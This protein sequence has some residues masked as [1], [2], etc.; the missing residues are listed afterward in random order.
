MGSGAD[1]VEIRRGP[2]AVR[3]LRLQ[4][5]GSLTG[6]AFTGSLDAVGGT[7]QVT[8]ARSPWISPH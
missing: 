8:F 3:P 4:A 6:L 5:G 7:L 2:G 1:R